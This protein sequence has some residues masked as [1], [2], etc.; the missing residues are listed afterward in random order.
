MFKVGD[1][2]LYGSNG[3]CTIEELTMMRFGRTRERYYILRPMFQKT[4]VIYVPAEN[5]DLIKLM[6][7]MPSREEVDQMIADLQDAEPIWVDDAQERKTRYDGIMR[8]C[9]CFSR[10]RMIKTLFAHKKYRLADGKNLH[11]SDENFLREAKRLISDEFAYPL[12]LEPSEVGSYISSRVK[13][14]AS[15]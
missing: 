13:F 8:S 1:Q 14:D 15:W 10:L 5:A 6:R 3:A 9:D 4:A 11:V 7:Q 12:Q 2:I